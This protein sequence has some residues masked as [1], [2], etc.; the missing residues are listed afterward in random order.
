MTMK[1]S[2]CLLGTLL[3]ALLWTAGQGIADT[4]LRCGNQLIQIGDSM[5]KV[6]SACGAPLSEQ[7]IGE[8]TTYRILPDQ[9]LK[10]KES[11]YLYE[12]LY[13][14]DSVTYVLTFEGS[15][16]SQKRYYK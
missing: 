14:K 8:R 9:Q 5:H 15:R 3:T 4:S 2:M 10:I 13:K 1:P 16:L 11:L 7:R 12:W 6:R